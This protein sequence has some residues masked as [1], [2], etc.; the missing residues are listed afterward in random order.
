[1]K[2]FDVTKIGSGAEGISA[3]IKFAAQRISRVIIEKETF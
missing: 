3:V 1:M 2:S